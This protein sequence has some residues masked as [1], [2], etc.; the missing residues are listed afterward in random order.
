[1]MDN[2]Y[3]LTTEPNALKAMIKP[4][5]MISRIAAAATGRS[6]VSDVL[7]DG[8]ISRCAYE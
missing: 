6:A 1:M 2:G 3:P 4:P 8:T 7:P 5:T